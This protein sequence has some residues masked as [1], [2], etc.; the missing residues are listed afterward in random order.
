MKK[1]NPQ[2][3]SV[4]LNE[5]ERKNLGGEAADSGRRMHKVRAREGVD[6]RP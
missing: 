2:R 3:K 1:S 5:S 4:T 6:D